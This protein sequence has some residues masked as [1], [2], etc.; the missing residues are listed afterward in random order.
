MKQKYPLLCLASS[1][2]VLFS[3]VSNKAI[4]QATS[5]IRLGHVRPSTG[6]NSNHVPKDAIE[7]VSKRTLYN[8]TWVAKDGKVITC[9]S[10]EPINYS[11]A[12]G[13]FKPINIELKSDAKGW[14]ASEQQNPCYFRSDRSTSISIGNG[15]EFGFNMNCTIS[16]MPLDQYIKAVNKQNIALDLSEGVHKNIR[17]LNNGIKTNYV[18]DKPLDG[19]IF[20]SEELKIPAG[21][22][23]KKDET[24]GRD[25]FGGWAGDY[26]LLSA[27]GEELARLYSPLVYDANNKKCAGSYN[28]VVKDGKYVLTTSVPNEWL[29]TATY[30][31]TLDPLIKG[32]VTKHHGKSVGSCPYPAY[33][34]D[35]LLNVVIPGKITI[36]DLDI[37][38]AYTTKDTFTYS[39]NLK[40]GGIYFSTT[41]GNN[42]SSAP[43][44]YYYC[45]SAYPGICY[46]QQPNDEHVP[47][48]CC[49][50]P[51]CSQQTFDLIA[52]LTRVG[53]PLGGCPNFDYVW[54]DA[55]DTA[56]IFTYKA[57]VS[58]YTDSVSSL[59]YSPSP[60]CSNSCN[61]LMNADIK[62]GVPPYKV[63]HP[64][65]VRDTT[66]TFTYASCTTNWNLKM[67]LKIPGCPY[68]CNKIDSVVHLIVPPPLVIDACGDTVKNI[69]SQVL[70]I[71]PQPVLVVSPDTMRV[72]PG[73]PVA[74]NITSCVAGT[75][76]TWV[77]SDSAK[78]TGSSLTDNT[79]DTGTAPMIVK[80]IIRGNANGCLSDP[81]T[82]VGILNPSPVITL[83]GLVDTLDLGHSENLTVTGGGTY[84]WQPTTGLSC[85][86]CPNPVASPTI[87]TTYSVTVTD[88][89][90][91]AKI[92]VFRIIVL[93]E[94]IVV[95]NVITPNSDGK[96]DYFVISGLEY[97]P[98]PNL[99][100]FDRW[101]KKIY[102]STNYKNDWNGGGQSDGVYYYLLSLPNGKK[103]KGYFQ[104]IK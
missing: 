64:W 84:D 24:K 18:F 76:F 25:W 85:S 95:P 23:F 33:S 83:K 87:T 3:G 45:D 66:S 63:S 1:L 102:N 94:N 71:N 7:D 55:T 104:I 10:S 69:K 100:I 12:N 15:L 13:N 81:D 11:D 90:G 53:Y 2:V 8:S 36:Y 75:N 30:P 68:N 51:S 93:D 54:Y 61:L 80:Y 27:S 31:I 96:D 29:K 86:T 42:P 52:H 72:C 32:P 20:V 103:F 43:T 28:L 14:S 17:F 35:T 70:V 41:C 65:A 62:F 99:T 101:G 59:S 5:G 89:E 44:G 21:C 74:L 4:S 88:T 48:T 38:Y 49:Y 97:Y 67:N 73:T 22:T 79:A 9:T 47:L 40:A 98:N 46:F 56:G 57:F 6:P 91:C 60:Q 16:G 19:G 77:G 82:A 26:V 78:G 92:L 34:A 39:V 58:G 37:D 50:L